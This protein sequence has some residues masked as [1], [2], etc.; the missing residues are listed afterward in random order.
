MPDWVFWAM[1]G[2]LLGLIFVA[3]WC[4]RVARGASS[5]TATATTPIARSLPPWSNDDPA[6]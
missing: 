5:T 2:G 6:A 1:L 3:G 4:G